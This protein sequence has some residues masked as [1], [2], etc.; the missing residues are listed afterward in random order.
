MT[1]SPQRGVIQLHTVPQACNF[2]ITVLLLL[3]FL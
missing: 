3:A 2:D 1:F